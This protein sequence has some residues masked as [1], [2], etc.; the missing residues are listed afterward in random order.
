MPHLS[1]GNYSCHCINEFSGPRCN[2]QRPSCGGVL[3]ARNGTLR[4]PAN[5][6]TQYSSNLRCAW[7]LRTDTSM[8]LNVTFTRFD[9]EKSET[10]RFDWLQIHDGRSSAAHLI[11]RFCGDQLPMNGNFLSTR[12]TLYMWFRSDS[13]RH[14]SGFELRWESTSPVCGFTKE[15]DTYGTLVSPGSPGEYPPNRDCWW[16][17]IAPAGKRIQF[18]FFTLSIEAHPDCEYDYLAIHDGAA[19]ESP[20]LAQFC[21]TSHPSPLITPGNT[22]T[23]HFH[24]DADSTDTGFQVHYSVVEGFPGCGGI[25]TTL[26]GE[27]GTPMQDGSYPHNLECDYQIKLPPGQRVSIQFSVF[28][29]ESSHSCNFDHLELY[30]GSSSSDPLVRRMC[31]SNMPDPYESLGNQLLLR[32]RSDYSNSHQGFRVRYRIGEEE[33]VRLTTKNDSIDCRLS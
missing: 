12:D 18:H 31:G 11:G 32:F 20:L 1:T 25:F 27:F 10:C 8:V 4:Y 2:T 26:E 5:E 13:S 30:E 23:V 7:M 3:N 16:T 6:N 29:I 24:S 17:L 9:L 33:N 15:F 28:D 21:N 19:L 22:A 14:H